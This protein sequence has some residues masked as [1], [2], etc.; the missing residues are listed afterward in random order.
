M[1]EEAVETTKLPP[2]RLLKNTVMK[3]SGL[4]E[5]FKYK[6]VMIP[7]SKKLQSIW[8]WAKRLR[9]LTSLKLRLR[10]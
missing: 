1:A 2:G 7:N 3:L 9:T 6:N 10:N 5:E 4:N 8:A